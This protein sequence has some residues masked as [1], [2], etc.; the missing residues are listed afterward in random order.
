MNFIEYTTDDG[1]GQSKFEYFFYDNFGLSFGRFFFF[2]HS[3]KIF[4]NY[5][6]FRLIKRSELD[7]AKTPMRERERGR[8]DRGTNRS[9][10]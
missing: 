9:I 1:A 10:L 5:D 3:S 8:G 7:G 4:K 6:L 2:F